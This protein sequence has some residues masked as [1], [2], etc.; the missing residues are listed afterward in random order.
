MNILVKLAFDGTNYHGTQIQENANTVFRVFQE[1]LIG[2]LGHK[3]DIKVQGWTAA[4][5][6]KVFISALKQIRM[7]T[8]Q[9]CH[10]P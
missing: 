7:S 6:R 8:S 5:M 1:A 3:T 4:Y 9:N 2:F 10:L